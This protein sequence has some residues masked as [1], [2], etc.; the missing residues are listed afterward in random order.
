VSCILNSRAVYASSGYRIW[1]CCDWGRQGTPKITYSN[2]PVAAEPTREGCWWHHLAQCQ[3][4]P[5]TDTAQLCGQPPPVWPPSHCENLPPDISRNSH[6][7]LSLPLILLLCS[8]EKVSGEWELLKD[9]AALQHP[10]FYVLSSLAA[11]TAEVLW[12]KSVFSGA[13]SKSVSCN[14]WNINTG[15]EWCEPQ[16]II[17]SNIIKT[18]L[19]KMVFNGAAI[20]KW[21]LS[22]KE[23]VFL[24]FNQ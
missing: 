24:L 16:I 1:S 22:F 15:K 4:T 23:N 10:C 2:L 21:I 3:V 5:R 11:G 6:C 7:W 20:Y 9:E 18:I 14:L 19:H 17:Q 8:S 13:D 12:L